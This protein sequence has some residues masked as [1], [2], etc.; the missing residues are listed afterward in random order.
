MHCP[1]LP[2]FFDDPNRVEWRE[3]IMKLLIMQF[4][5]VFVTST[6]LDPNIFLSNLF[7]KSLS[8]YSSSN[9]RDQVSH[10]HHAAGSI[11][12]AQKK[13]KIL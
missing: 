1:P 4:S 13:D 6:L 8:V 5:P 12:K 2:F 9:A 7:S 10:P 11:L 3:Q